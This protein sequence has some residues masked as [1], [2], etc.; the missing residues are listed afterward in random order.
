M[1]RKKSFTLI[2][3]V[4][5]IFIIILLVSISIIIFNQDDY[6]MRQNDGK[7]LKE[8]NEMSIAIEAFKADKGHYPLI[9]W[10][11]GIQAY[12]AINS[13]SPGTYP[14][15]CANPFGANYS[16]YND[17]WNGQDPDGA[18]PLPVQRFDPGTELKFRTS[19]N[20]GCD[21]LSLQLLGRAYLPKM[22]NDNPLTSAYDP[23]NEPAGVGLWVLAGQKSYLDEI[24][25]DP[26]NI[27]VVC[28][29]CANPTADY[30]KVT[31][32]PNWLFRY[33]YNSYYACEPEAIFV[34][35]KY[36]LNSITQLMQN[37]EPDTTTGLYLYEI[38][39][40]NWFRHPR[41]VC[42]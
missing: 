4:V 1:L 22:P 41:S 29:T 25:K 36:W 33:L 8:I 39:T 34:G 16:A 30:D 13:V 28:K 19:D 32:Q 2:E 11:L 26:L 5:V 35:D 10:G 7:R 40:A 23:T 12:E 14:A 6:K 9:N 42:Q 38:G 17:Y 15:E 20:A 27:S 3:L 21:D 31:G 18:G 37:G 24:P